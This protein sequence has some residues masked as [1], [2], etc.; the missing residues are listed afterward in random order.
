MRK[1]LLAALV[2][3]A[4]MVGASDSARAL[5]CIPGGAGCVGVF[6]TEGQEITFDFTGPGSM[7][8]YLSASQF[9]F[10]VDSTDTSNSADDFT[11]TV[12]FPGGILAYGGDDSW[13]VAV[14]LLDAPC[15][16]CSGAGVFE[17]NGD[18]PPGGFPSPTPIP[19]TLPLLASVL[20]A[21]FLFFWRRNRS[22][23][24]AV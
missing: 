4:A 24:V 20:A 14:T 21:G 13:S 10:S 22:A 1:V 15:E 6:T 18:P 2:G 3:A 11:S 9:S 16:G 7:Y 17:P 19:G 12:L 23:L 5:A 8:F